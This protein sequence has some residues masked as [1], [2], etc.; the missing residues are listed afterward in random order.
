MQILSIQRWPKHNPLLH[1]MRKYS[2]SN[3]LIPWALSYNGQSHNNNTHLT[4]KNCIIRFYHRLLNSCCVCHKVIMYLCS[5]QP[6][7]IKYCGLTFLRKLL[8]LTKIVYNDL[9]CSCRQTQIISWRLSVDYLWLHEHSLLLHLCQLSHLSIF[10]SLL[11][12]L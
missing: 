7:C 3:C 2:T 1:H 10:W 11:Q 8:K 6:M 5:N 4:L 12:R 9:L